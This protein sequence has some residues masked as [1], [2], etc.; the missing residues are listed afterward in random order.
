MKVSVVV[1]AHNEEAMLEKCLMSLNRQDYDDYEV[2]IVDNA[3]TDET[4][5]IAEKHGARV[6]REKRKGVA[7]A[8]QRG[9][10]KARGDV[11]ASTDADTVAS[12]DWLREVVQ[13]LNEGVVGCYGPV[14][15]LDGS[16]LDKWMAK[17]GFTF[18]LKAN[19]FLG[20]PNFSGQNFAVR[21]KAFKEVG[22]FDLGV[23][24]AEDV[25][26]ALRLR[27]AGKICFNPRMKVYTSA[28]RLKAGHWKFFKHHTINYFSMLFNGRTE[29]SFE[30]IR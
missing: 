25:N 3:S 5:A 27:K 24:S 22:G 12:E 2:I 8:R 21:K 16:K 7:F 28:R 11:I 6:L 26:L 20:F 19:H 4:P 9:F 18:F 14:Y 10:I 17:Y 23:R 29:R 30:D 13:A 15:L 1:P